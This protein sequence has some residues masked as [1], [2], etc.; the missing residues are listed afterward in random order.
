MQSF[1]AGAV[2]GVLYAALRVRSPAPPLIGLIGLAGM[3]IG[4]GLSDCLT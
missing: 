4:Y 2:V 3:L 1:G